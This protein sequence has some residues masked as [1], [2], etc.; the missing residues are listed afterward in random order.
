MDVK[1]IAAGMIIYVKEQMYISEGKI[2]FSGSDEIIKQPDIHIPKFVASNIIKTAYSFKNIAVKAFAQEQSVIF[3]NQISGQKSA[4]L[5]DYDQVYFQIPI[6]GG[7]ASAYVKKGLLHNG[8]IRGQSPDHFLTVCYIASWLIDQGIP[9]TVNHNTGADIVAQ[10]KGELCAFE[11]QTGG[12]N[13]SIENLNT[14][15]QEC[16]EKYGRMYFI[17]NSNSLEKMTAVLD[18]IS[19]IIARGTQLKNLLN[20]L[21]SQTNNVCDNIM[22]TSA[23]KYKVYIISALWKRRSREFREKQNGV[24]ASCRT[25]VGVN[26]LETHHISYVHNLKLHDNERHWIALCE[27]C[28]NERHPY[29]NEMQKRDISR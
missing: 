11:Y 28:H 3:S 16:I 26:N 23:S 19:C 1:A 9:C 8:Y 2:I 20:D 6:G 12:G 17:G 5:R 29:N 7:R 21:C 4:L 27:K 25:N 13:N 22:H 24:C 15:R 10:F 14:K 18:D